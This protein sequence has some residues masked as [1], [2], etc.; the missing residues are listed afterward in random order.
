MKSHRF[1]RGQTTYHCDVC[2]RLTRFTGVQSVG[3]KLCPHCYDL[4]GIENEISD[5]HATLAERRGVIDELVAAISA[6]GGNVADW[7]STFGSE[8]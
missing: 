4:A 7:R 1:N 8:A 6:K 2:G 3:S 5:G